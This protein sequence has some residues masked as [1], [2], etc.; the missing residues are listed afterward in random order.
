M[1][2][3]WGTAMG[4][5]CTDQYYAMKAMKLLHDH[6]AV[7]FAEKIAIDI[8]FSGLNATMTFSPSLLAKLSVATLEA[9]IHAV[10]E[11]GMNEDQAVKH[12]VTLGL[13]LAHAKELAPFVTN[14]VTNTVGDYIGA[15]RVIAASA[16]TTRG[17][18]LADQSVKCMFYVQAETEPWTYFFI[19]WYGWGF[20]VKKWSVDGTCVFTCKS[21]CGEC[22]ACSKTVIVQ[23]GGEGVDRD[24]NLQ[25]D[26]EVYG[27]R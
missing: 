5:R 6:M 20:D 2:S 19:P 24:G 27:T 23:S 25:V 15:G 8:M 16:E 11:K 22:D 9:G 26:W 14:Y 10:H 13:S 7:K 1:N 18:K 3:V 17:G 21:G 12:L 4:G